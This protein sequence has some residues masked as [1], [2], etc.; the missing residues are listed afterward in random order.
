MEY[1]PSFEG[2]M[3][4]SSRKSKKMISQNPNW[5]IR[6]KGI[7]NRHSS[8]LFEWHSNLNAISASPVKSKSGGKVLEDTICI[9]LI[10]AEK[11]AIPC[12]EDAFPTSLEGIPT[13]VWDGT[14]QFTV[15]SPDQRHDPLVIGTSV[16]R[17]DDDPNDCSYGTLGGF[18]QDR[19]D[20]DTKGFLTCCHVLFKPL[21]NTGVD[22]AEADA[23]NKEEFSNAELLSH[24][25]PSSLF[26]DVMPE[27]GDEVAQPSMGDAADNGLSMEEVTCGKVLRRLFK[28]ET[29]KD[30]NIFIDAAFVQ[31]NSRRITH[32]PL[33]RMNHVAR[34]KVK[35]L[36]RRTETELTFNSATWQDV[37]AEAVN[38]KQRTVYKCGCTTGLR[39]ADF[40]FEGAT[41]RFIKN[42][43]QVEAK[44]VIE[45]V[46]GHHETFG[47]EGDSGSFV[48]ILTTEGDVKIIGLYFANNM[49]C[50]AHYAIPIKPVLDCLNLELCQ[51]DA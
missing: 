26:T 30:K 10:C 18:V 14:V 45:I 1:K 24:A 31:V 36:I 13:D 3:A 49:S 51:F 41:F 17:Q 40:K 39:S 15:Y 23:D 29:I 44:N 35:G 5:H 50:G 25:K 47:T 33:A 22:G 43:I 7:I 48:F 38:K 34:K 19:N 12:G 16:G 2:R 20:P 8:W 32:A 9:V 28:N 6:L 4:H 46:D 42:D 27:I 37:A 11:K 21:Q